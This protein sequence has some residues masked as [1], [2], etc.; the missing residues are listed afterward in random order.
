MGLT[1]PDNGIYGQPNELGTAGGAGE[2][3]DLGKLAP[4]MSPVWRIG[5][6]RAQ[7]ENNADIVRSI[8]F[9]MGT[10]GTDN[11]GDNFFPAT[12]A[13]A[14][15]PGG[16]MTVA[17]ASDPVID[18]VTVT[19]PAAPDVVRI[20]GPRSLSISD[21]NGGYLDA[22]LMTPVNAGQP[23]TTASANASG[24]GAVHDPE[25]LV[26][27][28]TNGIEDNF[29]YAYLQRLADPTSAFDATDNPYLTVD[30][31][32]VE[33]VA[34][35]SL[36]GS[37]GA[38]RGEMYENAMGMPDGVA[39]SMF[40]LRS[41]QRGES[42]TAA[43]FPN[44]VEVARQNLFSGDV[45]ELESDATE[46]IPATAAN[47]TM[48]FTLGAV[49]TN[50][51]GTTPF[52]SL[53]WN[54]RPF[55]SAAEAL[56]VPY[57]SG[58][59]LTFFFNHGAQTTL[60]V[61]PDY[62][63]YRTLVVPF[64]GSNLGAASTPPIVHNHLLRFD[65]PLGAG[66][67][68]IDSNRFARLFDFVTVPSRFLGTETYLEAPYPTGFNPPF[69]FVPTFR[70]PGK[71]N[72]NTIGSSAVW[73]TVEGGFGTFAGA[74]ASFQGLRD[75][76]EGPTDVAGYFT[77]SE[78]RMFVPDVAGLSHLVP[79]KG[80]AGTVSQLDAAGTA[81]FFDTMSSATQSSEGSSYF[82]NELRQRLNG[83]TTTRSSV[84]AIWITIG[85][86]QIDEFGRIG[87]EIASEFG[88]NVKRN[89]AFYMIDRSI[90]VAFEPGRNH[91]VDDAVLLRTIIE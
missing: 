86:F 51:V 12:A 70:E 76:A 79:A 68:P 78:G 69:H 88:G 89:R 28:N 16:F 72:I 18:S 42:F 39:D 4:G 13:T 53:T 80:S 58:G 63:T 27:I 17:P 74:F 5:L 1:T 21:P 38:M 33:L 14:I 50:H 56:N 7:S 34:G 36:G 11:P 71:V 6:K 82:H 48:N 90:P 9:A 47:F 52:G 44:P 3:I 87:P 61:D 49:N 26:K 45:G 65:G 31:M 10:Y 29:R 43:L 8:Y 19:V 57:L 91:N 30:T 22:D 46:A 54:N 23:Y 67:G 77:S 75:I 55:A 84:F 66:A 73:D 15:A 59:L 32:P 2:T 40:E 64:F 62:E 37:M 25:D 60:A 85:Y 20:T 35:N 41:T 24:H 83:L 81:G